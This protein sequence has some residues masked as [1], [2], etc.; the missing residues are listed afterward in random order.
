MS[1]FT[2][3]LNLERHRSAKKRGDHVEE[4]DMD[5]FFEEL[6]YQNV[7]DRSEEEEGT[8]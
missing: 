8:L 4:L 7:S 1:F 3:L 5:N 6:I 2:I